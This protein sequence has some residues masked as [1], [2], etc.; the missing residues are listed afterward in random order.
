[1]TP[2]GAVSR[3]EAVVPP[4]LGTC[5]SRP[6]SSFP[7]KRGIHDDPTRAGRSQVVIPAKAGI[8]RRPRSQDARVRQDAPVPAGAY[9]SGYRPAGVPVKMRDATAGAVAPASNAPA[10]EE[11]A[12]FP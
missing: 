5:A 4:C 12:R 9:V 2:W 1:M 11:L 8:Q 3:E 6:P 7:R 10:S